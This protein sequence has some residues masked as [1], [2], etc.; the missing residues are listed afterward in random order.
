MVGVDG[1]LVLSGSVDASGTDPSQEVPE[2]EW[3]EL[4]TFEEE[5]QGSLFQ[6]VSTA[7]PTHLVQ[8]VEKHSLPLSSSYAGEL[9]VELEATPPPVGGATYP[10]KPITSKCAPHM[11]P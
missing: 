8:E 7:V 10:L 5:G 6:P 1:R 11:L 3:F 9:S 2:V 4:S